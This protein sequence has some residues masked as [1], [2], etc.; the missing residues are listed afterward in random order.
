MVTGLVY[1]HGVGDLQNDEWFGV[2][3]DALDA[4]GYGGQLPSLTWSAPKYTDLLT[5]EPS[6]KSAPPPRQKGSSTDRLASRLAY[7]VSQ[8]ELRRLLGTDD[9]V[10]PARGPLARVP[11]PVTAMIKEAAVKLQP[12]LRQAERYLKN[13]NL[14]NAILTRVLKNLP[15][16]DELVIVGHSLGSLVAID[17]LDQLPLGVTVRR[18]VTLG[19]PAGLKA[20]H[21]GSDRLLREFPYTH[22][23]SWLNALSPLDPVT[24]GRGLT[25][26]FPA[27]HDVRVD[28]PPGVHAAEAYLRNSKVALAIGDALFGPL[29]PPPTHQPGTPVEGLTATEAEAVFALA[30][31]HLTAHEL[32]LSEPSRAERYTKALKIVQ[33]Q[34]RDTLVQLALAQGRQVGPEVLSLGSGQ[35]PE[36]PR[37]WTFEEAVRLL[38]VTATTNLVAPWEIE[39]HTAARKALSSASFGLGFGAQQGDKI[40]RALG[41]ARKALDLERDVAWERLLLGATGVA[42]LIAAPIGPALAAPAGLAGAAAVTS[43]LAKFGP[44]GMIGGMAFAGTLVG[45]GALAAASAALV[46]AP[47]AVMEVEVVRRMTHARARKLLGLPQDLSDWSFLTQMESVANAELGRIVAFSDKNAPSVR[48]LRAKVDLVTKAIKWMIERGLDVPPH[49]ADAKDP[50]S[51]LSLSLRNHPRLERESGSHKS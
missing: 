37:A 25:W 36:C 23:Q 44:G 17:L 16:C 39:S 40:A 31:A 9:L 32:A 43:A 5:A 22:T 46:G 13:E 29:A 4:I 19:S 34:V 41:E 8:A 33:R 47:R 11:E 24:G 27:A 3:H 28:L 35:P 50:E 10:D 14:R 7:E 38:V 45:T 12:T 30:F 6:L 21:E 20:F 18:I 15:Q 26:L 2:L 42:L 48:E 51:P 1:L 49:T